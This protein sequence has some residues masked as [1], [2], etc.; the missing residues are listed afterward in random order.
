[1]STKMKIL[2]ALLSLF[3]FCA[4]DYF[5]PATAGTSEKQA[6]K[7]IVS[8]VAEIISPIVHP[9]NMHTI[10]QEESGKGDSR[11]ILYDLVQ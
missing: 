6:E 9:A 7:K 2:L 5:T 1:M 8:Q 4:F 3:A 10:L 11:M